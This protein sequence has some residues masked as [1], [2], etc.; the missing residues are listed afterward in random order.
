MVDKLYTFFLFGLV[1]IIPIEEGG[2]LGEGLTVALLCGIGCLVFF[3]CNVV[4]GKKIVRPNVVFFAALLFIIWS[5]VSILWSADMVSSIA[6]VKTLALDL[7][8]AYFLFSKV[9][10]NG[11]KNPFLVYVW[12]CAVALGLLF[13]EYYRGPSS[14]DVL[15]EGRFT[16]ANMNQNNLACV[17]AV[18]IALAYIL[19]KSYVTNKFGKVLLVGFI[20]LASIGIFLTGS[21]AGALSVGSFYFILL[22]MERRSFF[23]RKGLLFIVVFMFAIFLLSV[24]VPQYLLNRV[25]EGQNAGTFLLRVEIWKAGFEAWIKNPLFGVGSGAYAFSL[26]NPSL[27]GRVAHNTFVSVLVET[28]IIGFFIYLF[29]WGGLVRKFLLKSSQQ[30]FFIILFLIWFPFAF[31]LTLDYAKVTWFIWAILL[32]GF[33]PNKRR[34][35]P[36]GAIS[37]VKSL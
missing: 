20:L 19:F 16:A 31:S 12:G 23:S 22:F 37:E 6:R 10:L 36:L 34:A 27:Y 28:G 15:E 30:S 2:A 3:L 33:Y 11:V 13:L 24:F 35:I 14:M 8:F 18:G 26:D 9:S 25:S 1:F 32:A 29:L 21:R 7:L 4:S 5:G 17:L